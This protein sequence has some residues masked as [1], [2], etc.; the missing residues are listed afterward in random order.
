EHA[1]RVARYEFFERA[2]RYFGADV[3][4]TGHTRDDQAETFLL[5]LVRGAGAR[6]LAA[7]HPRRD[8]IVRPLLDCRRTD[9]R[10][11]LE[12]RGFSYVH[13]ATNDDVG[14]PRNRVRAEL[15]PLLEQRF[16][17]DIVEALAGAADVARDEWRWLSE[18]A[19]DALQEISRRED[20][21]IRLDTVRLEGLPLALRRTVLWEALNEIA[22]GRPIALSHVED[23]LELLEG[24]VGP[25]DL[26]GQRVQ[27]VGV[28]I[29]LTSDAFTSG[30]PADEPF[31]YPLTIPGQA[32]VRE[33]GVFV[34]ATPSACWIPGGRVQPA[35][36]THD[37][38]LP[39][40]AEAVVR[41]PGS[42]FL[43]VRGWRPGDKFRP[44]GLG[45]RKKLQDYF[46][47]RK[48]P[49]ADRRRV[50]LV[51]DELDRIVWVAGH[52]VSEDFRVT[53]P[54]QPVLVL[55]LKPLGGLA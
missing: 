7:I 15:L 1:A 25:V 48:V 18:A 26:P 54:A 52:C 20:G 21:Q 51:V 42:N 32:S 6:G 12:G 31:W 17:P 29:V 41:M 13:D 10:Q 16:N 49:R 37:A 19:A 28:E 44:F 2:R 8:A 46:V 11:Y 47:D 33:A 45:G 43:A 4:A 38:V 23:V 39:G 50:P 53:D 35:G 24:A 36:G 3:V 5:R 9:L 40:T 14:I 55:R 27:R 34:S 30:E 22:G